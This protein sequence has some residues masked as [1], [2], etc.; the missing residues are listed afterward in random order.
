LYGDD[1]KVSW[2]SRLRDV[3]SFPDAEA[4]KAQLDRDMHAAQAA[5]TGFAAAASH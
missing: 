2:V 5:L 3:M 4:L 1:V